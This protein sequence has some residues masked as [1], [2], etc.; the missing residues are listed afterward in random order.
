[1]Y[2]PSVIPS[3]I[4]T[5]WMYTS[6]DN[7]TQLPTSLTNDRPNQRINNTNNNTNIRTRKSDFP[8]LS[9]YTPSRST[10][11]FMNNVNKKIF[12]NLKNSQNY[13]K[14]NSR[15]DD[16]KFE[17]I[18]QLSLELGTR[19]Q[20]LK[21]FETWGYS[22]LKPLGLNKTM[23]Q[24]IE[25][26]N[27]IVNDLI[28]NDEDEEYLN[29]DVNDNDNNINS[30]LN[31]S[32]S[33][34]MDI[35]GIEDDNRRSSRDIQD[36][37][38]L[39]TEN[40]GQMQRND[41]SLHDNNVTAGTSNDSGNYSRNVDYILENSVDNGDEHLERDLDAELSDHDLSGSS[42]LHNHDHAFYDDDDDD[43]D[44]GNDAIV[45][46]DFEQGAEME[47][48]QNNHNN[49]NNNNNLINNHRID[50]S[51][52]SILHSSFNDDVVEFSLPINT[53][54]RVNPSTEEGYF[55]A[56]E[57]YQDDHSIIEGINN[58]SKPFRSRNVSISESTFMRS[59]INSGRRYLD[60]GNLT[61]PSTINS[62]I[63]NQSTGNTTVDGGIRDSDF[64]LTLD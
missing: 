2:L 24:L 50:D 28:D 26:S 45:E 38:H 17:S 41:N 22:Y 39:M 3:D 37:T 61:G 6:S 13:K 14:L 16:H 20:K 30:N 11:L 36:D 1:M 18:E 47:L 64:D 57:D 19:V 21:S 56:Y 51:S 10:P 29:N 62:T 52:R 55:M 54:P 35:I 23:N 32:N 4:R 40:L 63:P 34:G 42:A 8:P 15:F 58:D 43:Y 46:D 49:H 59:S 48:E 7:G 5:D 33:N 44:I 12:S 27:D 25:E 9:F 31:E 53:K 60:S